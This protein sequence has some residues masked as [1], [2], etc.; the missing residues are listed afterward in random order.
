MTPPGPTIKTFQKRLYTVLPRGVAVSRVRSNSASASSRALHNYSPAQPYF[1]PSAPTPSSRPGNPHLLSTTRL[2]IEARTEPEAPNSGHSQHTHTGHAPP[3]S[4]ALTSPHSSNTVSS[5]QNG[6]PLA[7]FHAPPFFLYQPFTPP[8]SLPPS[9]ILDSCSLPPHTS[10][11]KLRFHFDVGAYGIPKFRPSNVIS[12]R[13]GVGGADLW[14]H[15]SKLTEGLDLAVQVGEDAYFIRDNAMG[16]A[17]GVGGWSRTHSPKGAPSPSALFAR[18]LMHFCSTEVVAQAS[19]P[20]VSFHDVPP[21]SKTTFFPYPAPASP[22]HSKIQED[23]NDDTMEDL[24]DGLDVLLILERAYE[25]ALKAHVVA[26][27]PLASSPSLPAP[28]EPEPLLTGSSTALLAVLDSA[29]SHV[30]TPEVSVVPEARAHDAVIRI[31]HLGDCM[32]MLV[33]GD[34]IVWRSEEM[35]WR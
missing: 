35:W 5:S 28:I 14:S 20:A 26:P 30:P 15:N 1:D 4:L 32:G 19:T 12:G 22:T 18:R 21:S 29:G 27:C 8:S 34:G 2:P 6:I 31:A 13:D 24:V 33:R 9:A 11:S 3:S 25:R 16:V 17:D 23:P 7:N 10:T